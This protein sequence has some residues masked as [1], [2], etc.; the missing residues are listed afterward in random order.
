MGVPDYSVLFHN[1]ALFSRARD[2]GQRYRCSTEN[3]N[4]GGSEVSSQPT[5]FDQ[6]TGDLNV[7]IHGG[8]L[9]K[10]DSDNL[11]RL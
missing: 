1:S 4:V 8:R 2:G 7:L 9:L 6:H 5:A 11:A 3:I 10:N